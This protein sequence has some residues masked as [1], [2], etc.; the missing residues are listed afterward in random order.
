[1]PHLLKEAGAD[2]HGSLLLHQLQELLLGEWAL[3]QVHAGCKQNLY[4]DDENLSGG[5]LGPNK[6]QIQVSFESLSYTFPP[7]SE[8]LYTFSCTK[9][10]L[11]SLPTALTPTL[12][13]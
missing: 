5:E 7:F 13:P 8:W 10:V 4:L 6:I 2:P 11:L 12:F 1:M 3:L 9:L